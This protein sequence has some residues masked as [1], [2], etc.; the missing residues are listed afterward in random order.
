MINVGLGDRTWGK[1]RWQLQL[2]KSL[3][4]EALLELIWG[5]CRSNLSFCKVKIREYEEVEPGPSD[6]GRWR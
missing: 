5:E 1:T 4:P 3:A 6:R 2:A